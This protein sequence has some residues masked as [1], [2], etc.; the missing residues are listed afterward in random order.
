MEEDIGE[1]VN[2]GWNVGDSLEITNRLSHCEEKLQKWSRRK[3]K[4]FKE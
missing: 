1:V 2:E 4:R 3:R